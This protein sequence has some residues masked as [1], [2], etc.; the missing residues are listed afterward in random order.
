VREKE[1]KKAD[2]VNR[3]VLASIGRDL[4]NGYN[5][6]LSDP[7]GMAVLG[8]DTTTGYEFVLDREGRTAVVQIRWDLE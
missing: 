4:M 2:E 6:V 3:A 5:R 7:S 8:H 1:K